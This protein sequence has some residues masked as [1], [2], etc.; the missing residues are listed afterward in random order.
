MKTNIKIKIED[1]EENEFS[2]TIEKPT[3]PL[4][5]HD[6]EGMDDYFRFDIIKTDE[7]VEIIPENYKILLTIFELLYSHIVDIY[8]DKRI[9]AEILEDA[10]ADTIK[11]C[12]NGDE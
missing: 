11:K 5:L 12:L 7:S 9:I 10:E 3:H 2:I 4:L 6:I 1:Q 8:E